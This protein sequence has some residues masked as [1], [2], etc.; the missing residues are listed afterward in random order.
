MDLVEVLLSGD[1]SINATDGRGYTALHY[2]IESKNFELVSTVGRHGSD[3]NAAAHEDDYRNRTWTGHPTPLYLAAKLDWM[4]MVEFL[5]QH[6]AG[7]SDQNVADAF[8]VAV[9][10]NSEN[11]VWYLIENN[12]DQLNFHGTIQEAGDNLVIIEMLCKAG[13]PLDDEDEY[14]RS[15]LAWAAY[16]GWTCIV[17]K[18][19]ELGADLDKPMRYYTPLGRAAMS[20]HGDIV[21]VLLEAGAQANFA[22]GQMLNPSQLA[23]RHGF[24]EIADN[25]ARYIDASPTRKLSET[26][27]VDVAEDESDTAEDKSD[28]AEDESDT[29][30][31]END[32]AEA[33]LEV[34]CDITRAVMK[35][36]LEVVEKLMK[37]GC[38]LQTGR[39]YIWSPLH[40]AINYRHWRIAEKLVEAGAELNKCHEYEDDMP[41][42]EAVVSGNVAF[43][44]L[45]IRHGA[46]V[47]ISDVRGSTPL[48]HCLDLFWSA[49]RYCTHD[50][51][52]QTHVVQTLLSAGA[53]VNATDNFGRTPLGK[54]AVIG[55]F[56]AVVKLVGAGA[57]L[58]RPSSQ[59]SVNHM[60]SSITL[61]YRPPL[62]WAALFGHENVVRFLFESGAEWRSLQKEPAVSYTHRLLMQSWFPDEPETLVHAAHCVELPSASPK[63]ALSKSH[64]AALTNEIT[65][66]ITSK[67]TTGVNPSTTVAARQH[68]SWRTIVDTMQA[69]FMT[70]RRNGIP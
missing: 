2:A 54:A 15:P 62:A 7:C 59:N 42:M 47:N 16:R 50:E 64:A 38:T 49:Y 69:S 13:A 17:R 48:L 11:T 68:Q 53:N 57:D 60:H 66:P 30:E 44:E 9:A 10:A 1:C 41:F 21:Q 6:G 67:I 4:E 37:Q 22:G 25:I 19:V 45:M 43:I 51:V 36:D 27:P 3:I 46:D 52:V 24:G 56:E 31:D 35:G 33:P 70:N 55:N 20:G 26:F 5:L 39:N 23:I 65:K 34:K 61:V 18:L 40:F 29:A 12:V 63:C 28:K 14:G 32:L 58:N 8:R